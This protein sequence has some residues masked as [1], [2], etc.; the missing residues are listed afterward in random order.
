MSGKPV[1]LDPVTQARWD[2]W[3]DAR[4]N[5]NFEK[6]SELLGDEVGIL[7][8]EVVDRCNLKILELIEIME[9]LAVG[10]DFVAGR[11]DQ[12]ARSF[13][14]EMGIKHDEAAATVATTEEHSEHSSRQVVSV[15]RR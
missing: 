15:L 4:I 12:L 13:R 5:Q 7:T 1:D 10:N 2:A 11:V 14:M 3:C 9:A 8:R 6:F